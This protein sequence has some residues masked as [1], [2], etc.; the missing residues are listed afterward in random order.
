MR[1]LPV[2]LT[3]SP[4]RPGV[5]S[6]PGE[7]PGEPDTPGQSEETHEEQAGGGMTAADQEGV[8]T[9]QEGPESVNTANIVCHLSYLTTRSL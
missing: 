8:E 5:A 6:S 2:V 3:A 1:V 9:G 7:V 4:R